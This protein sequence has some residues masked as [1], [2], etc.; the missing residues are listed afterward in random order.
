MRNFLLF[1]TLTG[2]RDVIVKFLSEFLVT[3]N[4]V[5]ELIF[6]QNRQELYQSLQAEICAAEHLRHRSQFNIRIIFW[7]MFNEEKWGFQDWVYIKSF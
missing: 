3:A 1:L 4:Q 5:G 7:Q 2:N 6:R